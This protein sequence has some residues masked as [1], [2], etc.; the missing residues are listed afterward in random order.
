MVT[1]AAGGGGRRAVAVAAAAAVV[2]E[3]GFSPAADIRDESGSI[4]ISDWARPEGKWRLWSALDG[5]RLSGS[6]RPNNT[7]GQRDG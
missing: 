7:A 6:P 4:T 2:E 5:A 3:G 1:G